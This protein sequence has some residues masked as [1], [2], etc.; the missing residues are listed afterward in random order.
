MILKYIDINVDDFKEKTIE[1]I[2]KYI[3]IVDS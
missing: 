2:S 1:E 3:A